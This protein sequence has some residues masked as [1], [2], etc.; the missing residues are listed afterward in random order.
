MLLDRSK[1]YAD[2]YGSDT[3]RYEQGGVCFNAQGIELGSPQEPPKLELVPQTDLEVPTDELE[4][5]KQFLRTVLRTS[6]VSK[7]A[8][9]KAAEQNNQ[10]WAWVTKAAASLSI[11]K[12]QYQKMETWKLPQEQE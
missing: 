6:P 7:S 10:T 4:S 9:Y 5:A 12:F 1:P 3:I 11:V 8:V 2:V